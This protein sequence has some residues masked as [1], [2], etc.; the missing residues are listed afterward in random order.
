[1]KKQVILIGRINRG[2]LPIGGETAKNQALVAELGKYCQVTALDFYKHKRRPWVYLQTL[3]VLLKQRK[4]TIILSTTASNIYPLM[5]VFRMLGVRRNIIHWVV[6]GAFANLVEAGRFD[7][8]VLNIAHVHLVQSHQMEQQLQQCGLNSR[9]VPNFRQVPYTSERPTTQPKEKTRFVYMSRIM[10]EKGVGE[11][12]TCA[13]MMNDRSYQD[14]FTVDFYGRMDETYRAE[15][16][17]MVAELPNVSYRG[18]LD[19]RNSEGYRTLEGY[20]AMLFP[21]FHSSEGVAGAIIDAYL[22]GLPVVASDWGHNRE[23]VRDGET[24]IIIPAHDTEALFNVMEDIVLGHRDMEKL[25]KG[26][27][28]ASESYNAENVI[29]TNFLKELNIL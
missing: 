16:E 4:A 27:K 19:L 6:G 8:A 10:K 18:M 1:M 23:I 28:K 25:S 12:L 3:W 7:I 14:R 15:F 21:T 29:N 13:A 20:G 26:A 11:I 2:H 24:G 22:V 5:K 17:R 9:Y